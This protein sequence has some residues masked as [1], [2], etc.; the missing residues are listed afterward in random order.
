MIGPLK[1]LFA[2]KQPDHAPVP[3]GETALFNVY[4]TLVE[5][6]RPT[7]PHLLHARRDLSDPELLPHLNRFCGHILDLG[8]GQMSA[9][10]YHV[11]LHVQRVQHHLSMA[12][13]L[14]DLDAFH[15]WAKRANAILFTQD[16]QV[17]DPAGRAL[18]GAI[19]PAAV[20][21]YPEQAWARKAA[22]EAALA[23]RGIQVQ[24]SL[25]PL[26]SETELVLR[27]RD[28]VVGRARALLLVALRAESVASNEPMSVD[29]L[30][31]KMPLAEDY[32]SPDEQA[33][34]A[35]D[36]PTQKDCA[37]FLWRY[38]SLY[39]LEWAL[40]LNSELPFPAAPCDAART[41]ATLIEMRGPEL[42]AG[43]EIL[44]ALDLTYRLH[45]HIRQ[46]RLKKRPDTQ[47]LD[48]DVVM[49]R[50]HALNWLVRFQH[51]GWDKVD[52]PT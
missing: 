17:T 16:E 47:G 2:R 20:L 42:R 10:K 52:T 8:D 41:V 48:A 30:L 25:P 4:S 14:D 37:Q 32:L 46:Q 21:P 33:F 15:A 44:D 19:D 6:E 1:R 31:N 27:E 49:E 5:L 36:K 3:V 23:A 39:L 13:G 43:S 50:H 11:I 34:L 35:K 29:T 45:W 24:D 38:E 22:S 7:F 26:I 9:D 51:A 12:V 28:E 18:L 40:G